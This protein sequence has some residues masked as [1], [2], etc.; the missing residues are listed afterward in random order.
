LIFFCDVLITLRMWMK[1]LLVSLHQ[2][3]NPSLL[4]L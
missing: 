1:A 4:E 3:I 2:F